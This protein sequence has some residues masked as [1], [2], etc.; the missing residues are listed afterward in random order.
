[1]ENKFDPLKIIL[2]SFGIIVSIII[3]SAFAL[4][5]NNLNETAL[6]AGIPAMLS[7]LWPLSLDLFLLAGSIYILRANLTDESSTP[8]WTVLMV[9]T[10]VSTAFNV[11]HSPD[12][13]LSRSAHAVPPIALCVSLELLM[14]ILR[15]D[16]QRCKDEGDAKDDKNDSDNMEMT[17][18]F[19][20]GS[21]D[22]KVDSNPD[23]DPKTTTLHLLIQHYCKFSET[24]P[25]INAIRKEFGIGWGTA[26]EIV[27]DLK[28]KGMI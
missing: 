15:S 22:F 16:L 20:I 13:I 9:F 19:D 17:G 10:A 12:G 25:S 14:M 7:P 3:A 23:W 11:A 5:F 26:N 4:S 28:N 21:F 8:G 6:E 24:M 2:M 18:T 1:M 27:K